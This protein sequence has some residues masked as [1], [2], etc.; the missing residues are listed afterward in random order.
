MSKTIKALILALALAVTTASP[1]AVELTKQEQT[2]GITVAKLEQGCNWVLVSS[3]AKD[4]IA[5]FPQMLP[6][7]RNEILT[8]HKIFALACALQCEAAIAEMNVT[9]F[10]LSDPEWHPVWDWALKRLPSWMA[11]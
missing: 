5:E 2:L 7:H 1:G 6:K 11:D 3:T 8:T 9:E 4:R 10:D